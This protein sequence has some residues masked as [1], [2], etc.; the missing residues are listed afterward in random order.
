MALLAT[1][2]LYSQ[3]IAVSGLTSEQLR[4]RIV[5]H[6]MTYLG[7]PY[8]YGGTSRRG[9]DCSGL[10]WTTYRAVANASLPRTVRGQAVLGARRTLDQAQP[11]DIMIF[12]TL[13]GPTHAGIYLGDRKVLHAAY[14]VQN[15]VIVSGMDERYYRT[16]FLYA[17]SIIA[18]SGRPAP[19][20]EPQP[21]PPTAEIPV[22]PL[23]VSLG[24]RLLI[25][26][27]RI[28]FLTGTRAE[29]ILT[30]RAETDEFE[31]LV[32][33]GDFEGGEYKLVQPSRRVRLVRGEPHTLD[34]FDVAKPDTLYGAAARTPAGELRA[35]YLFRSTET[36]P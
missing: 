17:R 11:G 15:G 6:A 34:A 8:L 30:N 3:E 18:P 12:D 24:T 22:H 29:F 36:A 23:G 10:V 9:V 4:Q 2:A 33:E 1:P 35:L 25:Q 14:G 28:P 16:R 26:R 13:G 27:D 32:F 5:Q 7:V 20:T 31:I 21:L 19:A